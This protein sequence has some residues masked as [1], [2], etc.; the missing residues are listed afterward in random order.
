MLCPRNT[1]SCRHVVTETSNLSLGF[2]FFISED[3]MQR[4]DLPLSSDGS[5]S[6]TELVETMET[7]STREL[8]EFEVTR[9]PNRKNRR[10]RLSKHQTEPESDPLGFFY[11]LFS[12]KSSILN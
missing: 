1:P 4:D 7:H 10:R 3:E 9:S 11:L 12:I 8:Q 5:V 2:I 6:D